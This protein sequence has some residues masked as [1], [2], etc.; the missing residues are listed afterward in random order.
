MANLKWL[1][2]KA[3]QNHYSKIPFHTLDLLYTYPSTSQASKLDSSIAVKPWASKK[4]RKD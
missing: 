3:V 1:G 4:L 2:K